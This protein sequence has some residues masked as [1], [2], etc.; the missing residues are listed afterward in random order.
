MILGQL[1]GKH[2]DT[3][4][5]RDGLAQRHQTINTK[6]RFARDFAFAPHRF[7]KTG[8]IRRTRQR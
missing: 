1:I 4:V 7:E 3:D 2:G 5:L 8:T 6:C